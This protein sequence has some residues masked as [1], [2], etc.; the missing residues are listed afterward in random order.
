[1]KKV[2]DLEPGDQFKI[3]AMRK[4]RRVWK[5]KHLGQGA[6]IPVLHKNKIIVIL[7]DCG[8]LILD[9]DAEVVL[10]TDE[11]GN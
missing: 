4:W 2:R 11:N 6:N 7:N 9:P 8:Q 10:K 5:T 1:M 3:G